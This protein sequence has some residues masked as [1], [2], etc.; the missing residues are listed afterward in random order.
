M[1]DEELTV[2]IVHKITV[3]IRNDDWYQTGK[4]LI[5]KQMEIFKAHYISIIKDEDTMKAIQKIIANE[6]I[7]ESFIALETKFE[8][9]NSALTK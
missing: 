8:V 3:K 2:M 7:K 4:Y 9:Q 1:E 6:H 5:V